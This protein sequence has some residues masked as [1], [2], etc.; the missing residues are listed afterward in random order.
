MSDILSEVQAAPP[1][2]IWVVLKYEWTGAAP[3]DLASFLGQLKAAG[4]RI[5]GRDR[6]FNGIRVRLAVL[7]DPSAARHTGSESLVAGPAAGSTR[8]RRH[9]SEARRPALECESPRGTRA[10]SSVG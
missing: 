7:P 3:A 8:P 5:S 4:C 10:I 9:C 1:H 6:D 2:R